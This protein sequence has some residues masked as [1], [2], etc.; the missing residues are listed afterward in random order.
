MSEKAL[1]LFIDAGAERLRVF[2]VASEGTIVNRWLVPSCEVGALSGFPVQVDEAMQV[3]VTGNFSALALQHWKQGKKLPVLAVK[4]SAAAFLADERSVALIELS[5]SG[6]T[7]I[8]VGE[9]GK[10]KDDHLVTHPRCGAGVG[11]NIDRVLLKL[12]LKREQVDNL[13]FSYQGESGACLRRELPVRTDRCGVFASSATISDKNQGIPLA[14]ALAVTLKSEVLKA[15]CHIK[16]PFG[17]V[18]LTGGVFG[19]QFCRDCAEDYLRGIGV[20]HVVHDRDDLL[21]VAGLARLLE[22]GDVLPLD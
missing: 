22:K 5:A 11:F 15:C 17:S 2:A 12:G 21:T 3:Y 18:W 10:L 19:W 16:Q 20:E 1:R 13:L 4:W 9:D 6:Y 8:G 14:Y 7:I